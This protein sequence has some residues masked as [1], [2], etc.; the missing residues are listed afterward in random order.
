M[1]SR[2]RTS[3]DGLLAAEEVKRALER[4]MKIELP[5]EEVF[6]FFSQAQNLEQL[7]PS[8]LRFEILTPTP[9]DMKAGTL[10]DY[11]IRL[12]GI[13]MKWR[14]EITEFEQ[15]VRFVDTQLKGP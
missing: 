13:P 5:R 4:E 14:T 9:I 2:R 8:S 11:K 1:T 3:E 12:L 6:E 7:T 15:G 10:I